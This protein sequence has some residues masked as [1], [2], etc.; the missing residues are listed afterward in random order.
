MGIE[1][2]LKKMYIF[3]GYKLSNA[4]FVTAV[5]VFMVTPFFLCVAFCS[6]WLIRNKT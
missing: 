2:F 3:E 1:L 5:A 6:G 4:A